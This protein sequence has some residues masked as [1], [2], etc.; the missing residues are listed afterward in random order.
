M[1]IEFPTT[2]AETTALR[3][4]LKGKTVTLAHRFGAEY[5]GPVYWLDRRS[6]ITIAVNGEHR[7]FPFRDLNSISAKI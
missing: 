4:S 5:T 3:N 2:T 1:N 7:T 6:G